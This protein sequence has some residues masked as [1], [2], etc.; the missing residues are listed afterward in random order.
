MNVYNKKK[1]IKYFNKDF[2]DIVLNDIFLGTIHLTSCV[3]YNSNK[4]NLIIKKVTLPENYIEKL[5]G[6]KKKI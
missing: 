6:I 3:F 5:K 4:K 1:Y 2:L